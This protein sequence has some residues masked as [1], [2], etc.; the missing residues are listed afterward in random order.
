MTTEPERLPDNAV[1]V[2]D[3]ALKTLA[4]ALR[5]EAPLPLGLRARVEAKVLA[6]IRRPK[7]PRYSHL[8]AGC[9]LFLLLGS[10]PDVVVVGPLTVLLFAAVGAYMRFVG[11]LDGEDDIAE[12]QGLKA[13][14]RELKAES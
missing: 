9:G 6:A 5:R 3:A 1:A 12:S 10:R 8:A 11:A 13:E 7:A 2:G 14:S 4:A